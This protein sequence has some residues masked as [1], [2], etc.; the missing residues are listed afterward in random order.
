MQTQ[1]CEHH[2]TGR[3]NSCRL[4][5]PRCKN[6]ILSKVSVPNANHSYGYDT[7]SILTYTFTANLSQNIS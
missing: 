3:T 1:K 4:L 7:H 5:K 6:T 2:K